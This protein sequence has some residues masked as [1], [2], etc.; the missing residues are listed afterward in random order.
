[1]DLKIALS[2]A[3]GEAGVA[4]THSWKLKEVQ[5]MDQ[6]EEFMRAR[7]ERFLGTQTNLMKIPVKRRERIKDKEE[8]DEVKEHES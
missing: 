7:L 4:E 8:K 3:P 2:I 6:A 1:M 5:T